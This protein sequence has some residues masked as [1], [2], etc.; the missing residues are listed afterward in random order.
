MAAPASERIERKHKVTTGQIVAFVFGI[1]VVVGIFV[2]A[3]PKFA[4]YGAIWDA[5]RTLTPLELWSL[6][7]VM[8]FNLW[9]YWIAN[10]AGLIGMD[11]WQSAVVTQ[12]STSVAN[13][14]PAGGAHGTGAKPAPSS[15]WRVPPRP[16]HSVHGASR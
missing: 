6:I 11:I 10:E 14:L 9:T 2:F 3:I 8:V 15:H 13:T 12:T 16:C 5:M 1:V 4:D 7:A